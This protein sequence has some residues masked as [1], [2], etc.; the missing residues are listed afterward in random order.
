MNFRLW[1]LYT[2]VDNFCKAVEPFCNNEWTYSTDNVQAMWDNLSKQ[3][4]R[5]FKFNMIGLDWRKYFIDHHQS[6]RYLLNEDDSTLE[7]SRIKYKR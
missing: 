7:I 1:N 6:I 4:Q 5:L 2:K 3:D